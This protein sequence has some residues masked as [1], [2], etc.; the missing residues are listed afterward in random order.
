MIVFQ[1]PCRK[2]AGQMLPVAN[3]A[4]FMGTMTATTLTMKMVVERLAFSRC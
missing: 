2:A 3:R 1:P 4:Q